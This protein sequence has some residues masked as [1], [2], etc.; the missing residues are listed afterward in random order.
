L[1]S[2]PEIGALDQLHRGATPTWVDHA[3]SKY[4]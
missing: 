2:G 3:F 1:L 4:G